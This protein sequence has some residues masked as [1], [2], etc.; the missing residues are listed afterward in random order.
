MENKI[1]KQLKEKKYCA[2]GCGKFTHIVKHTRNHLGLKKGDYRDYLPYH[3]FKI[4]SSP[5]KGK[6]LSTE[7]REKI[8]KARLGWKMPQW[9]KEKLRKIALGKNPMLNEEARKKISIKL[10]GKKFSDEHKRKLSEWQKG[11]KLTKE[12]RKNIG[13]AM[14]GKI[15]GSNN[16]NW[17]GG[18]SIEPY[19]PEFNMKFKKEIRKRDNQVCMLCKIHREK[20]KKAL[21]IH[22]VNYDK[23]L[24]IKENCISLC[25][26]CHTKTGN[27]RKHWIKF[28]QSLLNEKYGYKYSEEGLAI[29]QLNK[30]EEKIWD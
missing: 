15:S 9:H 17:N 19:T 22:H 18:S 10:K 2:C 30:T 7:T 12:H 6:S 4:N 21:S 14:K 24:T 27:N 13:K 23:K 11:R 28:F 25:I 8:S 29:I 16:P 3:Y 26:S 20:L 5:N 1:N